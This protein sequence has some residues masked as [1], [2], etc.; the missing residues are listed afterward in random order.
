MWLIVGLGNPGAKYQATRHNFGFWL[1]DGLARRADIKVTRLWAGALVGRGRLGGQKVVL[2]K[3]Q[4][5]MNRSGQSVRSLLDWSG[6]GEE[7]LLVAHDDLDLPLGRLKLAAGGGS[8]GHKGVASIIEV[9]GRSDFTRLKAG[10]GRPEEFFVDEADY[11]LRPFKPQEIKLAEQV[12][13]AG[14]AATET[15]IT[16]GLS[17]AQSLFNRFVGPE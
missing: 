9:L 11:V 15:L 14:V 1:I 5:F 16:Q 4:T 2:A 13:E 3:P 8:G 7:T 6:A 17:K 12:V 10:I